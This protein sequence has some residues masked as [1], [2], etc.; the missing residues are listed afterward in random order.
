MFD[1]SWLWNMILFTFLCSVLNFWFLF[2]LYRVGK[3]S[4]MNQYPKNLLSFRFN[5]WSCVCVCACFCMKLDLKMWLSLHSAFRYVNRKFSNQ[6]KATIGADFLTKE[7]QFEDRLFTLQVSWFT[8]ICC[9]W[10]FLLFVK[11]F[12]IV[13]VTHKWIRLC[14]NLYTFEILQIFTTTPCQCDDCYWSS[15]WCCRDISNENFFLCIENFQL[16]GWDKFLLSLL[17]CIS[18]W[19]LPEFYSAECW[20]YF[21]INQWIFLLQIS[22]CILYLFYEFSKHRYSTMKKLVSK[23]GKINLKFLGHSFHISHFDDLN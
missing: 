8:C 2:T 4:L 21:K 22:N 15:F 7:V 14:N 23:L 20:I 19:S 3:T 5:I 1:V 12:I 9:G 18:W 11:C 10:R 6:Y 17:A 16:G 13:I